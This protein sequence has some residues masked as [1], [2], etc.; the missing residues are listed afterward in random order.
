M[1]IGIITYHN[2]NNFGAALQCFALYKKI[3]DYG[4]DCNII[5]YRNKMVSSDNRNKENIITKIIRK[6]LLTYKKSKFKYFTRK[7]IRLS[8][9]SYTNNNI[10]N[11]L[12]DLFVIGSDQVWN[13]TINGGDT[14]YFMDFVQDPQKIR[15][16]ACSVGNIN[17]PPEILDKYKKYLS[18]IEDILV[19]EE[20]TEKFV[21]DLTEKKPIIVPDPVFLM[22]KDDWIKLAQKSHKKGKY[23]VS[24]FVGKNQQNKV[25][26]I[27]DNFFSKDKLLKIAGGLSLNDIKSKNIKVDFGIS[28]IDFINYINNAEFVI[29]DSFHATAFCLI[30]N[31]PFVVFLAN[32][33]GKDSRILSLLNNYGMSDHVYKNSS[34]QIKELLNSVSNEENTRNLYNMANQNLIKYTLKELK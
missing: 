19:R 7:N 2:T 9:K 18:R 28:P 33:Y 32:D 34:T 16:Y 27:Y 12:Y 20:S 17:I 31:K 3:E 30:L 13:Y 4:H 10:D 21:C 5:D 23:V 14:T 22:S 25:K 29:T 26:E 24:Y 1:K 6:P 11:D 15:T 8:S